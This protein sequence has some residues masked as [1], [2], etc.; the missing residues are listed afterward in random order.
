MCISTS[1]AMPF[2]GHFFFF[3]LFVCFV[4]FLSITLVFALK[5]YNTIQYNTIQ[6]STVQYNTM[7]CSTILLPFRRLLSVKRP[8]VIWM[9]R[10]MRRNWEE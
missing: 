8:K 2:L 10:E 7:Q 6:Y 4:L 9:G 3:F 1:C 5:E